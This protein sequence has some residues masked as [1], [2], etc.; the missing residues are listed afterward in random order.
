MVRVGDNEINNK[1]FTV[2]ILLFHIIPFA[3]ETKKAPHNEALNFLIRRF[4]I[5]TRIVELL[6]AVSFGY[7]SKST[8]IG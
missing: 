2:T 6:L 3:N 8:G 5:Y 1:K 4:G 7:L